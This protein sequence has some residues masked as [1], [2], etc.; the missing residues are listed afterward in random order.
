MPGCFV[1]GTDT[2]VGKTVVA[3]ALALG[4]G[5]SY[6]KPV[7]SGVSDPP[8]PATDTLAVARWTGLPPARLLPE[9]YR[10][11]LPASPH[12]SAAAEGATIQRAALRLPATPG[13]IVVEG[14][15]GILVP[16]N[17]RETMADLM[18]WLGL[19]VVLVAR[20]ALGTINHTLLSLEALRHRGLQVH[21]LILNGPPVPTTTA[22]LRQWS[23]ASHVLELAPL[24]AL[25]PAA[26]AAA[27]AAWQLPCP[28]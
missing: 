16:L 10:F 26:L 4:W 20:T 17:E 28:H 3:A 6:W 11:P 14:A 27:F 24:P 21:A 19:P 12:V 25:T 18:I 23:G 22:T 1:T 5:A 7:Q 13:A 8:E 2:G 15:G 9:A